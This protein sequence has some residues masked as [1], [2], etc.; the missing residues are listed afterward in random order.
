MAGPVGGAIGALIGQSIDQQLLAPAR[1]GPRVGDLAVQ[2]SSYGTQIPRI[3]GTM[4]VAGSVVWATDLVESQQTG[5]RQ[6]PAG[7]H[8]QLT[9]CPWRSR[10]RRVR[11]TSVKRIWA[12]GKLLRGAAGELQGQRQVS[13][14]QWQRDQTIDP[15]IGSIEG[16]AATPAYRGLALAVFENLELATSATASRS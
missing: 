5:G 14:L 1:R 12:D 7:R 3:Y 13:L 9:P 6:G 4:R 11:A 2:T 10:C 15:L 8:L 16:I